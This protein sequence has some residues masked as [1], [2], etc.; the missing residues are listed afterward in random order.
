MAMSAANRGPRWLGAVDRWPRRRPR[1]VSHAAMRVMYS[2]V[3]A[4]GKGRVTGGKDLCTVCAT[5]EKIL[6]P[7]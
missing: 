5:G 6:V 7:H 4:Q 2:T 3:W 1:I